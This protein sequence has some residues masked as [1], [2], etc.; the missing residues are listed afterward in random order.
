MAKKIEMLK[1]KCR[2]YE[3]NTNVHYRR[4][5]IAT[6]IPVNFSKREGKSNFEPLST[7]I[8]LGAGY[9]NLR[10]TKGSFRGYDSRRF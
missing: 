7:Q 3:M 2:F 8:F 1:R 9:E 6:T 4:E 10:R 5:T